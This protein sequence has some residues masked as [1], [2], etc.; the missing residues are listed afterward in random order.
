MTPLC[1]SHRRARLASAR[2][3]TLIELMI[4]VAVVA[5]LAAVAYPTYREHVAKGHRGQL[6]TQMALAQQWME[7]FYSDTYS[8]KKN[9]AGD[10]V[11]GAAGLFSKQP[12][13]VSPPTGEGSAVYT[14]AV[15]VAADGQSYTLTATRVA[16]GPMGSD[17]C[18]NP[19]VTG[20]GVKGVASGTFGS[21]Y[22][23]AVAAVAECWR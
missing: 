15:D 20:K 16:T 10:T 19:T 21:R 11:D 7:R 17:P 6:K 9:T 5:I 8:Y 18:G 14:L 13:S 3:F 2:G 22:A 12:F 23:T 4:A 1:R